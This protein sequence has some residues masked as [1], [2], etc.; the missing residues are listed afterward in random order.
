MLKFT[1]FHISCNSGR[2][3]LVHPSHMYLLALLSN[4]LSV[5]TFVTTC[6]FV[7]RHL[8]RR[9]TSC[10]TFWFSHRN[11]SILPVSLSEQGSWSGNEHSWD[12]VTP[13]RF[14]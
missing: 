13:L 3:L 8:H 9:K 5:Y 4:S 2:H 11:M 1:P 10:E 12:I 7:I 6:H 14:L